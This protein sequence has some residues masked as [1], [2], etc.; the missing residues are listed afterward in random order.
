MKPSTY[1]K[2][3]T[4]DFP[5]AS[6]AQEQKRQKELERQLNENSYTQWREHPVT[7]KFLQ[8]LQVA[9]GM[10]AIRRND[11]VDQFETYKQELISNTIQTKTI[12]AVLKTAVTG[13][14]KYA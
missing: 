10:L 6:S 3:V 11:I 4:N 9:Q 5:S 13:E 1:N 7:K 14:Y 8:E 12:G 2:A